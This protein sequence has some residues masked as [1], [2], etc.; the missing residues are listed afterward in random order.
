MVPHPD[1]ARALD[2]AQASSPEVGVGA[3]WDPNTRSLNGSGS[4]HHLSGTLNSAGLPPRPL[5]TTPL[6]L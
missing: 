3:G 5:K 6:S 1:A 2:A 4:R